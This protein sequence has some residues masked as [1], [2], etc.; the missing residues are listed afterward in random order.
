MGVGQRDS[1]RSRSLLG[2]C[3][4]EAGQRSC[5]C[6]RRCYRVWW[7]ARGLTRCLAGRYLPRPLLQVVHPLLLGRCHQDGIPQMDVLGG[8]GPSSSSPR[9]WWRCRRGRPG[10]GGRTTGCAALGAATMPGLPRVTLRGGSSTIHISAW[11]TLPVL[12]LPRGC[13]ADGPGVRPGQLLHPDMLC[14]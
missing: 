2:W 10:W 6:W 4:M 11:C 14:T 5:C 13:G 3:G 9:R 7:A 1:P 8:L 12:L